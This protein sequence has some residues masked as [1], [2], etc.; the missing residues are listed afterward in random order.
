[1]YAA[2]FTPPVFWEQGLGGAAQRAAIDLRGAGGG[3]FVAALYWPLPFLQPL[4]GLEENP[5]VLFCCNSLSELQKRELGHQR[6]RGSNVVLGLSFG[7]KAGNCPQD[8][9]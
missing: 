6:F 9:V 8:D 1:M 7:E 4:L 2:S 3:W 5:G